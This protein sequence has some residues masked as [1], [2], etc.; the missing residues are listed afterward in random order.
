MP[1]K[2]ITI[3]VSDEIA[4]EF[5]MQ[6]KNFIDDFYGTEAEKIEVGEIEATE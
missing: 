2:K 1:K 5:L 6:L 3:M 4:E